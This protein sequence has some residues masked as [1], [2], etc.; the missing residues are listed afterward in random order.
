MQA[1]VERS[2]D[3]LRELEQHCAHQLQ[4]L[5]WAALALILTLTQ[6]L[7]LTLTLAPTLALALTLALT[8]MQHGLD[9]L[10]ANLEHL[11]E[12]GVAVEAM[13][14]QNADAQLAASAASQY[15]TR[16]LTLTLT[17]TP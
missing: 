3:G 13:A 16:D 2:E 7:L 12:N 5:G 9:A 15:D 11:I 4:V 14:R 6:T 10:G 8:L 17:L 1:E